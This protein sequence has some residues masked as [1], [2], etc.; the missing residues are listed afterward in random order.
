MP[1]ISEASRL[2]SIKGMEIRLHAFLTLYYMDV[3]GQL[4]FAV[5]H[6]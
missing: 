5:Y 3:S 4:Y 2:A 6:E 1:L